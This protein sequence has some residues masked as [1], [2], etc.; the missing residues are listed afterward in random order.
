MMIID[1][2]FFLPSSSTSRL[3]CSFFLANPFLDDYYT[4][5]RKRNDFCQ[6]NLNSNV[7]SIRIHRYVILVMMGFGHSIWFFL[8]HYF[9]ISCRYV[10]QSSDQN[11]EER[12]AILDR[13]IDRLT[14]I[15]IEC[16]EKKRKEIHWSIVF[17]TIIKLWNNEWWI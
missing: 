14:M 6:L 8:L 4:M 9:S 11:Q 3:F 16:G 2:R 7:L 12:Y 15:M 17:N 13:S 1:H 10:F 5:M